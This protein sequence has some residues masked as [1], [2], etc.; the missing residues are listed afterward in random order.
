MSLNEELGQVGDQPV[1]VR[2]AQVDGLGTQTAMHYATG[3]CEGSPSKGSLSIVRPP[4][5]KLKCSP[6]TAMFLDRYDRRGLNANDA[7]GIVS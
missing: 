1:P 2:Q 5:R 3:Q 6:Q 7:F 4:H